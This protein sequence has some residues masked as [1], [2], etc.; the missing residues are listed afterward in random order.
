MIDLERRREGP[1]FLI[2]I[3][4]NDRQRALLN[5]IFCRPLRGLE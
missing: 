2:D 4:I 5:G 1:T 3:D